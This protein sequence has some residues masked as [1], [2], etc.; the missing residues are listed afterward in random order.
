MSRAAPLAA[1]RALLRR[2]K[3]SKAVLWQYTSLVTCQRNARKY[4]CLHHRT[5]RPYLSY[6]S[7]LEARGSKLTSSRYGS[8]HFC[9][10]QQ[11]AAAA[12]LDEVT[13]MAAKHGTISNWVDATSSLRKEK[14]ETNSRRAGGPQDVRPSSFESRRDMAI[15]LTAEK[16]R[17]LIHYSNWE[18]TWTP[19]SARE[20][21]DIS[22]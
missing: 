18:M 12:L 20:C 4:R 10:L 6:S 16:V 17:R 15:R 1:R 13:K 3:R 9:C 2:A 5:I 19:G 21:C 7:K 8:R 11:Q 14:Y 22:F